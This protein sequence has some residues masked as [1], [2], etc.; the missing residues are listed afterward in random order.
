MAGPGGTVF[1]T[2]GDDHFPGVGDD[3]SG[4]EIIFA[5]AGNDSVLAG[6]GND[7]VHGGIGDDE[8]FGEEGNDFLIGDDGV[9]RI[10]GGDGNDNIWDLQG[11]HCFIDAG[12]GFD[13]IQI[14]SSFGILSVINGGSG[15]DSLQLASLVSL[16][17]IAVSGIEQLE[18]FGAGVTATAAQFEGFRSIIASGENPGG[19]LGRLSLPGIV[20]GHQLL[21]LASELQDRD[22]FFIGS[23]FDDT[24]T[25]GNGND[26]INGLSGN[27][28]LSGRG[29]ND[30]LN[31]GGGRDVLTG[32]A[33]RDSLFGEAGAD[34][35]VLAAASDSV[36]G[37]QRDVVRDFVAGVD[38]LDLRRIDAI[39][40]AGD[41]AFDFIETAAFSGAGGELR[42]EF[43]GGRTII[44][45]DIDGLNG[46][47]FEIALTG[48][49]VLA[50]TDFLL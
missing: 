47:D 4:D 42:Y 26:T 38:M 3:N 8:L 11:T 32:G 1:L 45:G 5:D 19:D 24:L 18:T 2:I 29:G 13:S 46:A 21:N 16:Q 35:F 37:A 31:G 28:S 22:V 20:V 25:M 49:I 33:G 14:G 10:E 15:Y 9:D 12:D 30:V 41:D 50:G 23:L 44:S 27:D 39:P 36:T 34:R 40:G 6:I 17:L 48:N 43:S 7:E